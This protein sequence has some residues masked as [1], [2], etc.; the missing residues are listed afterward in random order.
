MVTG[1]AHAA[2]LY[3][4]EAV[5]ALNHHRARANVHQKDSAAQILITES[6]PTVDSLSLS[7][8]THTGPPPDIDILC[9]CRRRRR[10]RQQQREAQTNGLWHP[11]NH[12]AG[13]PC[14]GCVD[15]KELF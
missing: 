10:R 15:K 2:A 6:G 12:V 13:S 14:T 4:D 1:A 7:L 9:V 5:V 11:Y 8:S 3:T